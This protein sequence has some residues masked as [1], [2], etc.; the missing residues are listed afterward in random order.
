MP[1]KNWMPT[2]WGGR[3]MDPFRGFRHQLDSL[4]E[5]WFGRSMGGTLAPRVDVSETPKEVT[6]QVELPGVLEK[7]IDVSLSG[8]QLTIKG[9]KRAE[10]EPKP[11]EGQEGGSESGGSRVFHRVER[12]F[13]AFQRTMTVPFE[14][15]PDK[16]SAEFKDGVLTITLPKPEGG[17]PQQQTRH[18]E[19]KRVQ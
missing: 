19:V 7:D 15:E 9:E 12:S 3:E 11:A 13:G 1:D 16:V 4:F 8:N 5:D 6:L 2:A 17:Q 10:T 18:I 14:V